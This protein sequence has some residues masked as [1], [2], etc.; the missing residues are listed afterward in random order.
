MLRREFVA[1][2]G[3]AAMWSRASHAQQAERVRQIGVLT[4]FTEGDHV[5]QAY[6]T[7]FREGLTKLGWVE[8][9]NLRIE[10][11]FGGNDADRFR[12]YAAELVNL[13]PDVILTDSLAATR[14]AQQQTRTIPIVITGAGDVVANGI[15][16]SLARPEGNITGITGFFS[17]FGGKWLELLKEAAP[18]IERVALIY[19][20][21][22]VPDEE[23]YG[24]FPS[25][26]DAARALAVKTIKMPYRNAVDIMGAIDAF[27]TEPN[28]GLIV[29]PAPPTAA[30][31]LTILQLAANHRLP[32]IYFSRPFAA[33][34]GLMAYGSNTAERYRRAS[35][36]VD[37]ILRGTKVSE[38][39]IEFP[40]KFELVINLKTARAM[41]LTITESF[42]L[43]ADEVIE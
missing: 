24:Y 30:N 34:G 6:M 43:R 20:A 21:Q 16:K 10:L 25:I 11:R 15:V 3:S 32:A 26:E 28:G 31:R 38:L 42:L 7:A 33:E 19:N 4:N 5:L 13:A 40:T 1:G 17:S 37:R 23:G 29:L 12:A 9:R 8:E 41:G 14:A 22:V 35:S 18:R 27:A 39:P 2:L 36:F